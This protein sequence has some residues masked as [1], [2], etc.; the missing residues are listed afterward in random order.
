MNG[1][2]S[3]ARLLQAER[4]EQRSAAAAGEGWDRL[5]KALE[6]GTPAL[7]VATGALKS[8]G[9]ASLKLLIG[10]GM[11]V[12][13]AGGVA[14]ALYSAEPGDATPPVDRRAAPSATPRA[15][16]EAA[17]ASTATSGPEPS[18]S[19]SLTSPHLAPPSVPASALPETASTFQDELRLLEAA[20]RELDAGKG[21]LALI[22][23]DEHE[24][25]YPH[26]VFGSE[27]AGL[28]VLVSCQ[29]APN[30]DAA[31]RFLAQYPRSPLVD[32]ISRACG[33]AAPSAEPTEDQRPGQGNFPDSPR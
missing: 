21:Y 33:L 7:P 3:L 8:A 1:R 25:R 9:A 13:G 12:L 22:L 16:P 28:R 24:A 31:R 17:P 4:N 6:A 27:R 20:K 19:P 32:R 14:A 2:S 11:A 30:P 5:S 15:A 26:G 18:P 10:A 23:L 29:A